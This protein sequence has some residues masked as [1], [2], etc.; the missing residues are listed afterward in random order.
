[1]RSALQIEGAHHWI[2]SHAGD[3]RATTRDL[4]MTPNAPTQPHTTP[5]QIPKRTR[6]GTCERR[7]AIW[8]SGPLPLSIGT[9]LGS[10]ASS[11]KRY[12]APF[13]AWKTSSTRL[14]R[15]WSPYSHHVGRVGDGV[16]ENNGRGGVAR[17]RPGGRLESENGEDGETTHAGSAGARLRQNGATSG[18]AARARLGSTRLCALANH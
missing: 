3:T 18:R 17:S 10:V 5:S 8:S 11:G 13:T 7:T 4:I 9:N 12:P 1:M 14:P 16:R 15:M 2:T 6:G